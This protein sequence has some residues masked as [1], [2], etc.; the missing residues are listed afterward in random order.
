M[1]MRLKRKRRQFKFTMIERRW[2]KESL[3]CR[4]CASTP[5]PKIAKKARQ[6]LEKG[7]AKVINISSLDR[8]LWLGKDTRTGFPHPNMAKPG[9]K[10]ITTK[11]MIIVPSK[12]I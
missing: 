1:G 2:S 3:R 4:N 11:G 12:S 5:K 9:L 6:R 7:P 8:V 10:K